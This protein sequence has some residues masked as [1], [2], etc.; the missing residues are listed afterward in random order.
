MALV[1]WHQSHI[2]FYPWRLQQVICSLGGSLLGVD[3]PLDW[4]KSAFY[5]SF[6]PSG[7]SVHPCAVAPIAMVTITQQHWW[8]RV[9]CR[10]LCRSSLPH[11]VCLPLTGRVWVRMSLCVIERTRWKSEDIYYILTGER[12]KWRN[13]TK[14][15]NTFFMLAQAN[16]FPLL[17]W[18]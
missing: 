16:I 12:E 15:Y 4:N 8:K 1:K 13:L 3:M 2:D 10:S 11:R 7:A 14:G 5:V 6:R 18:L 17:F 9:S